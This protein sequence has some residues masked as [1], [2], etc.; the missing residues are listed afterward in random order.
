[1]PN[2]QQQHYKVDEQAG[3]QRDARQHNTAD[4]DYAACPVSLNAMRNE[5]ATHTLSPARL[6]LT[7]E[8]NSHTISGRHTEDALAAYSVSVSTAYM[9]A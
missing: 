4:K 7:P 2:L 8:H 5:I 9:H 3:R 6:L 1:M